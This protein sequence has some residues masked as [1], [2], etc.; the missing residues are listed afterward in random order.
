VVVDI[1]RAR[2]VLEGTVAGLAAISAGPEDFED[3]ERTI[4]ISRANVG[5]R[6]EFMRADSMFH[7][8]V[9][10]ACHNDM[11]KEAM[12][13]VARS[14]APVRDAY[15]GGQTMDAQTLDIHVRQLEAMERRDLAAL[16]EVLDEHFRLLEEA[17]SR[18]MGSDWK[19]LFGDL[20]GQ[21]LHVARP[22]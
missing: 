14:L 5:N 11:L 2:R 15:Q 17:F 3:I 16:A 10:R 8:A 20:S 9:V 6:A 1:V 12:R 19:K 18:A 21:M 4:E 22:A 7:R 13:V